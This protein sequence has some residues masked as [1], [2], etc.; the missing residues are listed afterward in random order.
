MPFFGKKEKKMPSAGL[1][2][3]Q[4]DPDI[5]AELGGMTAAAPVP[6]AMSGNTYQTSSA[7]AGLLKEVGGSAAIRRMTEGFY[8]RVKVNG[9]LDVFLRSH[10]DPHGER[11]ANWIVEKMG[12]EGNVWSA[13]R[14]T[15][16]QEP[17]TLAGGQQIVV[18]DRSSA[19]YA[20]WNS[21]KRRP[22]DAGEHF[23]LPDARV[24]MRLMFWSAREQGL[25]A[26]S[27]AFE[28][29]YV[30]F[31]A[32]FVRV[33]ERQAPP[34]ARLEARWSAD[35]KNTEAYLKAG[36]KMGP[37]V[38]APEHAALQQLP[39]SERGSAWPYDHAG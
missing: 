2:V 1:A 38:Q 12:G 14:Q 8:E 5:A 10:A 7:S 26:K 17:V 31:I 29:W 30:R 23:K 18:N 9:H 19:H 3:L 25:F 36:N 39:A 4:A 15:R 35:P 20:A 32:H 34:F 16:S 13:E 21:P 33:Y 6:L 22:E 27:P 11:L 37:E 28:S 24:W